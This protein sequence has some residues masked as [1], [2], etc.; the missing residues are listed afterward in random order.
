MFNEFRTFAKPA[1]RSVTSPDFE[2]PHRASSSARHAGPA[3]P[4]EEHAIRYAKARLRSNTMCKEVGEKVLFG[5]SEHHVP[6]TNV[7]QDSYD[8]TIGLA[9]RVLARAVE[10]ERG[11]GSRVRR[12]CRR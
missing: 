3:P 7:V 6:A 10:S 1:L 5:I 8:A 2:N 11:H 9:V 12:P 4:L